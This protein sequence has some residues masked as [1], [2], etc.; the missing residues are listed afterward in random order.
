MNNSMIDLNI[1]YNAHCASLE[2]LT[3]GNVTGISFRRNNCCRF[4]IAG[5]Q[6]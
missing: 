2:E 4:I 6:L 1:L 3:G 5:Q